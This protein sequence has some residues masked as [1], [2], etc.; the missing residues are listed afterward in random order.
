[1]GRGSWKPVGRGAARKVPETPENS[2]D[3]ARAQ[4]PMEPL[5]QVPDSCPSPRHCTSPSPLCSP[6]SGQPT[7]HRRPGK[8]FKTHP[9]TSDLWPG[10]DNTWKLPLSPNN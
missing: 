10:L 4:V 3:M 2:E 6:A 7:L 8:L 1:M 5:G 9:Q